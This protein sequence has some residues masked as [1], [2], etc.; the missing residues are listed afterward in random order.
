VDM[1]NLF[2]NRDSHLFNITLRGQLQTGRIKRYRNLQK[3]TR[4]PRGFRGNP[5]VPAAC[6]DDSNNHNPRKSQCTYSGK[7]SWA[8]V[9]F[10]TSNIFIRPNHPNNIRVLILIS[11]SNL[12]CPIGQTALPDH[13]LYRKTHFL[14]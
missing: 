11:K 14:L 4:I 6:R 13:R 10:P 3:T 9:I 2:R 8:V 12:L 7:L 1:S 5:S